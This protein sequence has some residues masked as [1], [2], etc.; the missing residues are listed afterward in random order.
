MYRYIF[1][2]PLIRCVTCLSRLSDCELFVSDILQDENLSKHAR[3]TRDVLLN[4]FR[5]I[6]SRYV[7]PTRLFLLVGLFTSLCTHRIMKQPVSLKFYIRCS[8]FLKLF[9]WWKEALRMI[10][11]EMCCWKEKRYESKAHEKK[12]IVSASEMSAPEAFH[13][14]SLCAWWRLYLF[15]R[16]CVLWS[17]RQ[18]TKVGC[19]VSLTEV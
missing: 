18:E 1:F 4:N 6:Y 9:W 8:H 15:A 13:C 3:E 19:L 7:R 12:W 17:E 14:F 11:L 2:L 5:V 16:G 10:F